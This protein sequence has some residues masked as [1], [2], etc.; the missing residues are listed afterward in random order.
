M[1]RPASRIAAFSIVTMSLFGPVASIAGVLTPSAMAFAAPPE[2]PV[3]DGDGNLTHYERW[4]RVS[5]V[6]NTDGSLTYIYKKQIYIPGPGSAGWQD[7]YNTAQK[8]L[9][10][11]NAS[12]PGEVGTYTATTVV[13]D[14]PTSIE[15]TAMDHQESWFITMNGGTYSGGFVDSESTV[16]VAQC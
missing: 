16:W 9:Q 15:V 12:S 6:R 3:Y 4:V 8:S 7:D 11:V 2:T 13:A 10:V 5:V 14:L 1:K